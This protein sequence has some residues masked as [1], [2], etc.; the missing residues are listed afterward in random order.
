[1]PV[2]H[3]QRAAEGLARHHHSLLKLQSDARADSVSRSGGGSSDS[4]IFLTRILDKCFKIGI[5]QI[6]DICLY[7]EDMSLVGL[8][9]FRVHH[10]VKRLARQFVGDGIVEALDK[11]QI[12]LSADALRFAGKHGAVGGKKAHLVAVGTDKLQ[13]VVQFILTHL[14]PVAI[15]DHVLHIVAKHVH[16]LEIEE[17]RL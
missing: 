12:V 14:F 13:H 10:I 16:I 3:R 2:A 5:T 4:H 7:L 8:R 11:T 6:L 1:M 15:A 9:P 17:H